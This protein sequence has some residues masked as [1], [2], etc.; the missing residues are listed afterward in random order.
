MWRALVASVVVAGLLVAGPSSA[1]GAITIGQT[2]PLTE[3]CG[4]GFDWVQPTV[5]SGNP[6]VVPAT[7]SAGR[8]TSWGTDAAVA[9]G[10][11]TMKVFRKVADPATYMAVGHDG[12]R[13]LTGGV[14]TFAG[15]N[16]PVRAGDVLGLY[17]VAEAGCGLDAPG[18]TLYFRLGDLADGQSGAFTSLPD[19]RL[20]ISAVVAPSNSFTFGGLQRNK[21]KGTATLTVDVPNPGELIGSGNG[22]SAAAAA[23]ISKTVTAPGAV[24]LTIKA[25][26]K[27]KR[28]LNET[29]KVKVTL[30]VSYTPTG[31]DPST[32]SRKL[33]L[34]KKL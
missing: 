12:P 23:V 1:T 22:I 5:T 10:M 27:K 11:V 29:G 21:R 34:K 15:I 20:N 17:T 6:Y 19:F 24:T 7:V 33:K 25:R 16:V 28:K 31:G 4:A 18:D 3:V 14:N 32:Q 26:G 30:N 13:T 8:I 2:G 9:G